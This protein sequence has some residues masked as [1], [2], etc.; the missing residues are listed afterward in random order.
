MSH[1]GY[2]SKCGQYYVH[3][4]TQSSILEGFSYIIIQ[5]LL[6]IKIGNHKPMISQETKVESVEVKR[7]QNELT[8]V[9]DGGG[10]SGSTLLRITPKYGG[11]TSGDEPESI[12]CKIS[13]GSDIEWSLFWRFIVYTQ[14]GGG[15]DE[16]IMRNEMNFLQN[17]IPLMEG[18]DYKHPKI[19][20]AGVNNKKERGFM[21][22]VV[23]NTPTNVNSNKPNL[24]RYT[25][26]IQ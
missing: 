10:F 16:I 26:M 18:T 5:T 9:M 12:I 3:I 8:G 15:M 21:A 11:T 22:S 6:H 7:L 1:V 2:S 17:A 23:F 20:Y 14:N 25:F 13:L 24:I 4:F 19:Y